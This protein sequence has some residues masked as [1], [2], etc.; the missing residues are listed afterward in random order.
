MK[1]HVSKI[2]AKPE[3]KQVFEGRLVDDAVRTKKLEQQQASRPTVSCEGNPLDNVFKF[4]YLSTIFTA[5]GLQSYD[6]RQRIDMTM[7]RCG[8]LS[9]IFDSDQITLKLKLRLYEAAVCSILTYGCETWD[10]NDQ[11]IRCLNGVNISMLVRITG[12]P[13]AKEARSG[14][15]SLNLVRKIRIRRLKWLGHIIRAGPQSLMFC[16]LKAQLKM[17]HHGNLLMDAAKHNQIED[18]IPLAMDR[19]TWRSL[20]TDIP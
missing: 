19:A 2:H 15:T 10:L 5:N 13:I 11:T 17:G 8:Q 1:I 4:K 18:L 7:S 9:S 16:A 14:T 12:K 20:A 3:K 6:V